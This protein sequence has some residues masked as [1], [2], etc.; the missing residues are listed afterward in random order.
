MT[1]EEKIKMYQEKKS[2]IEGLSKVFEAKPKGSTVEAIA[3]EVYHKDIVRGD[4]TYNH[5]V[6]FV[7]VHFFGGAKSAKVVSGNS[8]IANFRVLGTLVD[9]G[10]YG[11]LEYY[12]SVC[13]NGYSKLI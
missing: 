3:Y 6:E 4:V 2:F 5:I 12:N 7:V 10:D 11:E 8:N 13:N 9:G 1:M